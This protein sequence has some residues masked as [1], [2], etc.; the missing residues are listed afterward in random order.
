MIPLFDT[1]KTEREYSNKH[2][3]VVKYIC[4][5][6]LTEQADYHV[7]IFY[8]EDAHPEFG[9]HYFALYRNPYADNA[10]VTVVNVDPIIDKIL[11]N[12]SVQTTKNVV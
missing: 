9:S 4:T 5:T 7:D 2:D 8:R 1:K 3:T 10:V 11:E 6:K 12:N